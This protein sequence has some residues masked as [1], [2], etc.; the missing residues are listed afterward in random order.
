MSILVTGGAGYV[1]SAIMECLVQ[2]GESVVCLDNLSTGHRAAVHRDVDFVEGAVHDEGLVT[3]LLSD[4]GVEAVI[5]CAAFSIVPESNRNPLGYFENNVVGAHRL[6]KAMIRC[7][8][9]KFVLSSTAAIYGDPMEVPISETHPI[10]PLNA[11]GRSKRMIEEMLEWYARAYRFAYISLRYF[12]AAGATDRFGEDHHPETHLIPVVLEAAMETRPQVFVFGNDYPTP[13]GSC[14]RDYIHVSDL[15]DAH[16][17]S[18]DYLRDGGASDTFNLGAGTGYS[19]LEVLDAVER[20]TGR[21]IPY[22]IAPR[23]PG[24]ATSLVA[25]HAKARTILNWSPA[26]SNLDNLI[27]DAWR[28]KQ[29]FPTGYSSQPNKDSA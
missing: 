25:S 29:R 3:R 8:V 13:D 23:R 10:N 19:V 11:Y 21:R 18:I 17:R 26:V 22:E 6:L 28:W 16:V 27:R 20:I 1:G 24:D 15:A 14:I 12:N 5:H 2:R 9:G 7:G 4:R